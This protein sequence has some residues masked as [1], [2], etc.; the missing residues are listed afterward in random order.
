MFI[1]LFV[2]C[3]QSR[4]RNYEIKNSSFSFQPYVECCPDTLTLVNSTHTPLVCLCGVVGVQLVDGMV[5]YRF[6]CGSG[7]GLIRADT[8]PINDGYWHSVAVERNSRNVKI[9]I[10]GHIKGEGTAPGTND[11][12]NLDSNDVFF[13]SEVQMLAHG[14][15]DTRQ[16]FVG[17]MNHV[18]IDGVELPLTG[19]A[20]VGV[21]QNFKDI[22]FHCRGT[23]IP[24]RCTVAL[25]FTVGGQLSKVEG[26]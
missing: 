22:E 17:C 19:S 21:L 9:I 6:D 8:T 23:Y 5:Q 10:D 13:G 3:A 24:G 11:V 15:E 16:G 25:C 1:Q 4:K 14:Y 2:C 26:R 7:E 20:S 12:L 18:K